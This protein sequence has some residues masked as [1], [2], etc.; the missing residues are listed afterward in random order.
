MCLPPCRT[1][2]TC[3]KGLWGESH[4]RVSCSPVCSAVPFGMRGSEADGVQGPRVES[5]SEV[6]GPSKRVY[7]LPHRP[8]YRLSC[9]F[10]ETQSLCATVGGRGDRQPLTGCWHT[11]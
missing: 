4:I 5:C 6:E 9:R 3:T 8:N 2:E 1:P 7:V 10:R 11:P